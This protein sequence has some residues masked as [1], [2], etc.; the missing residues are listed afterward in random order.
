MQGVLDRGGTELATGKADDLSEVSEIF[1]PGQ[2]TK[3]PGPT[4]GSTTIKNVAIGPMNRETS[5]H[6]S[7]LRPLDWAKPALMSDKVPQPT[8][9]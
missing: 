3:D 2:G 9:N 7:P 5:H 6:S 1:R 8:K 4:L